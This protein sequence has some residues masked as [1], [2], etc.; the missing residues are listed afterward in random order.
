[1]SAQ[2]SSL[3]ANHRAAEQRAREVLLMCEQIDSA[4]MESLHAGNEESSSEGGPIDYSSSEEELL[5]E[6]RDDAAGAQVSP[7][8]RRR[9]RR[10]QPPPSPDLSADEYRQLMRQ[11]RENG[12]LKQR[13]MEDE[14]SSAKVELANAHFDLETATLE[15]KKAEKEKSAL[16]RSLDG[17]AEGTQR[18]TLSLGGENIHLARKLQELR[19]ERDALILEN[20]LLKDSESSNSSRASRAGGTLGFSSMQRAKQVTEGGSVSGKVIVVETESVYS[21]EDLTI[22][23]LDMNDELKSWAVKASTSTEKEEGASINLSEC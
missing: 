5:Q 15:L 23:A 8:R 14:L 16:R 18:A 20:K 6:Q 22:G 21:A 13:K 4:R 17:L 12:A 1:M 9:A 3:S 10:E 19:S 11:M 2:A 7:V